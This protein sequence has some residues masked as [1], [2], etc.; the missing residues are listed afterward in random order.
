[1]IVTGLNNDTLP[2]NYDSNRKPYYTGNTEGKPISNSL[3]AYPNNFLYSGTYNASA[4]NERGSRGYLWSSTSAGTPSTG[5]V[6]ISYSMCIGASIAIP[7]TQETNK[8]YGDS[9]RCIVVSD[10]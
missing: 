1:M 8:Y 3:R 9:I 4:I 10:F 2:A 5:N 6:T 7:G